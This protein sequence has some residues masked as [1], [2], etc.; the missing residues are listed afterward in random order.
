[1]DSD[2]VPQIERFAPTTVNTLASCMYRVALQ[3]SERIPR[4]PSVFTALGLVAHK[5][6]ER[7]WKGEF[8]ALNEEALSSALTAAWDD[9]VARQQTEIEAAYPLGSPPRASDWPGYALTKSRVIRSIKRLAAARGQGVPGRQVRPELELADPKTG[10]YGQ[11]DRLEIDGPAI[12]I[13]DLKSGLWQHE[14]TDQQRRQLMLYAWLVHASRGMWPTEIAI[15]SAAGQRTSLAVQPDEIEACAA[16]ARALVN[17]YNQLAQSGW[18]ALEASARPDEATCRWCPMRLVCTPYW[19]NLTSGWAH[20]GSA[21]GLVVSA[22]G[23]P[24]GWTVTIDT[25]SPRDRVNEPTV[26]YQLRGPQP[27]A[28]RQLSV[29]NADER[30]LGALRCRWDTQAVWETEDGSQSVL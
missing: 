19:G 15:E 5:M 24:G 29:V 20:P 9:L 1:M 3:R 23:G 27:A 17:E 21:R 6:M 12:T 4:R 26:V 7:Y 18:A 10:L 14:V 16:Q 2:A 25:E 8:S 30:G 28:G 22:D 11:L 13:I